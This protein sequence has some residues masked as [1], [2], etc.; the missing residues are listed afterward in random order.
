MPDVLT[1]T[2]QQHRYSFFAITS[3]AAYLVCI[4]VMAINS[5]SVMSST[6]IM[7]CGAATILALFMPLEAFCNCIFM[8]ISF[9]SVLKLPIEAFSFMT[10]MQLLLIVRSMFSRAK[11]NIGTMI[12]ISLICLFTQFFPI[13]SAGQ[14]SSNITLLIFNV[15][16]FYCTY[17]LTLAERINI[18]HAYIFFSL[19]TLIAGFIG[20]NYG[21]NAFAN[22]DYRFAGLWTDP[23]FWGMFC[24][25]GIV[26][27]MMAGF[28]RPFSFVFLLP[29]I[30]GL[31]LQ[32]FMTLSR[33]FLFVCVL[34]V[35]VISWTSM[36]K[37]WGAAILI[38]CIIC[39]GIYYA[40]PY[41]EDVLA[42]RRLNE[43]D[44]SNGRFESTIKFLEYIFGHIE[45]LLFGLGYSNS[46]TYN[47]IHNISHVA[48]HNTYADLLVEFGFVTDIFIA[49]GLFRSSK[50]IK[51][52][53]KSIRTMPGLILCLLLFYMATLSMLKYALVYLFLGTI[54]GYSYR[55]CAK[56]KIVS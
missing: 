53:Y 17:K 8:T 41:A 43:D 24:L 48:T 54:V 44:I 10:L 45:I 27:C 29:I 13:I 55:Q 6:Y 50:Y 5:G 28:R 46:L 30:I 39:V 40:I 36:K 47:E 19:G 4:A 9:T 12:N 16:T 49:I 1:N 14:N 42:S 37:N 56:L 25:I 18:S 26:S 23:N 21:I 34:M 11:I 32:G 15:L 22:Q 51:A 38:I 7:S 52:L 3:I 2:H 33:T 35:L 20:L 31:A